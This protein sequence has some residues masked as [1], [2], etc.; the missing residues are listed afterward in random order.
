MAQV[1]RL[2]MIGKNDVIHCKQMY[3]VEKTDI[4][5]PAP[6]FCWEDRDP[7]E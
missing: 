2:M 6:E 4:Y 1:G 5:P 7:F 3:V